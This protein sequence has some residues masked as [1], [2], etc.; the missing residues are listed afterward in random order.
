MTA[1]ASLPGWQLGVGQHRGLRLGRGSG[2]RRELRR[3]G[4][5]C[6]LGRVSANTEGV[7]V[8]LLWLS[9]EKNQ[10]PHKTPPNLWAEHS[11]SGAEPGLL[12][13]EPAR[14]WDRPL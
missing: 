8:W 4:P 3:R 1:M 5:A 9:R 2:H 7:L 14:P 10:V 13:L 12:V 11:A 6:A